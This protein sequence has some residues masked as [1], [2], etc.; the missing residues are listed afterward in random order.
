MI[1]IIKIP[2]F[3]HRS[4]QSK[5]LGQKMPT[6]SDLWLKLR[7]T[8]FSNPF[9]SSFMDEWVAFQPTKNQADNFWPTLPI[10][11]LLNLKRNQRLVFFLPMKI[12]G[13]VFTWIFQWKSS[14]D[15]S[16][17]LFLY[18]VTPQQRFSLGKSKLFLG[19]V[20]R[21]LLSVKSSC[22]KTCDVINSGNEK[23]YDI[24]NVGGY[25]RWRQIQ[26]ILRMCISVYLTHSKIWW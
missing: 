26:I 3:C 10:S 14:F 25:D 16:N 2:K 13:P 19:S 18:L 24:Y 6:E 11:Y 9:Y 15:L 8:A 1:L 4:N 20:G 22:E 12:F 17:N 7:P 23:K 21:K 5:Y